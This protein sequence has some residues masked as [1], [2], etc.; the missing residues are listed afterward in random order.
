[1]VSG[2]ILLVIFGFFYIWVLVI[3]VCSLSEIHKT[4]QLFVHFWGTDVKTK[5]NSIKI[6]IYLVKKMRFLKKNI[7]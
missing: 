5:K 7:K 6:Y 1:M 3:R 2:D 4:V